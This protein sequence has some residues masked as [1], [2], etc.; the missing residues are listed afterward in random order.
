MSEQPQTLIKPFIRNFG[1]RKLSNLKKKIQLLFFHKS[2]KDFE[3]KNDLDNILNLD[4][5]I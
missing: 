5:L 4:I 1:H 3:S 2:K